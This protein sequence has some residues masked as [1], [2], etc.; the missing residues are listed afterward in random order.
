MLQEPAQSPYDLHFNFFGFPVRVAWGFWLVAA[1]LGWGWSGYVD[2]LGSLEGVSS[3]GA[4][5]LLLV[6]M[7][8]M[9]VSILVHELGHA[10]AMR[11]YGIN[12]RIVLYHFGGLAI[13]DSF[14]A[15]NGA[16]Q[17]RV[18]AREQLAISAA[19]PALQL[20]LALV[21][22]LIGLQLGVRMDINSWINRLAG[23]ELGARD[24]P[25]SIVIYAMFD[26]I[27]YP[28]TAWAVLNLV[29]I[30]P[31]DGGQIMHNGL[32][33]MRVA[34]ATRVAHIISIGV[35]ALIGI[36]FLQS[37]QP[38]GIMFLLFAANNWQ[39]LQYGSSGY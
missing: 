19:G 6:W 1:I 16:R 30:I 37:G 27:I 21:V 15:W 29:P 2:S 28:S 23:T 13:P 3:P 4:P 11:Y 34:D 10:L 33:M 9:L 26:A 7:S 5:M 14:G 31:L 39:A 32:M 24:F 12:S 22:W 17:R 8:G 25:N 20:L 35:G 38:F 36:Y 18:G